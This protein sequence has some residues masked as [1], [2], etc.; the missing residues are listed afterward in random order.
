MNEEP[1]ITLYLKDLN[2]R[3]TKLMTLIAILFIATILSFSIAIT[4]ICISN[5]RAMVERTRLYFQTD[6]DYGEINNTTDVNISE[7]K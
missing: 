6:Y 3:I 5:N 4:A 2:V 7:R 1:L